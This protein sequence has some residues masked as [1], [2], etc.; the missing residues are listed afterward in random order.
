MPAGKIQYSAMFAVS[1]NRIC[2]TVDLANGIV[3][4]GNI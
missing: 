4:E 2:G 1:Q 3:L